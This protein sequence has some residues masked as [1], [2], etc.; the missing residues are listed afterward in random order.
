M[1]STTSL[2]NIPVSIS[3]LHDQEYQNLCFKITEKRRSL[4]EKRSPTTTPLQSPKR[5]RLYSCVS[6]R[7]G[8]KES[9]DLKVSNIHTAHW[10]AVALQ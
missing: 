8:F 9:G 3:L 10:E 2:K 1:I 6:Q 7:C 5:T 4:S